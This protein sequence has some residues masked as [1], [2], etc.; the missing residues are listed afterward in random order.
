ML[1]YS[2]IQRTLHPHPDHAY[3]IQFLHPL[4][5]K[6]SRREDGGYSHRAERRRWYMLPRLQRRAHAAKCCTCE[7]KT[8]GVFYML[9]DVPR[10]FSTP[11]YVPNIM[12][13]LGT[14]RNM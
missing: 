13:A 2:Y 5:Y 12:A 8:K 14:T 4:L 7:K 1:P 6:R 10:A 3:T 9:L 11:S